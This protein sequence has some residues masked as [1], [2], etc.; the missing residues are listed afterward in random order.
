MQSTAEISHAVLGID[1]AWTAHNP[2]GVALAVRDRTGWRLAAVAARY[3]RFYA[4]A[5]GRPPG[6]RPNGEK[7]DAARLLAAAK[8][9]A[10][11]AVE[12]VAVDMP[13]AMALIE[14][15]RCSDT[16][17]SRAFGAKRCATHSPNKDRPGHIS[18]DVC[19][20]LAKLGYPLAT[21]TLSSPTL[22]E[23][24]P[25]P[26][27]VVWT[28][29]DERL[30]YKAGKAASYWPGA[31]P[32]QRRAKLGEVWRKIVAA[33]EM[34]VAGVGANLPLPAPEVRGWRLEAFEDSLDAVICA[35][36]AADALE[37]RATPYGD[38]K[39]AIWVPRSAPSETARP[40]SV[41]GRPRS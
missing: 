7:P 30:P 35:A 29:A 12:I 28:N 31:D 37:G 27:L 41:S 1:A 26:A 15:R 39:S 14:H 23:V 10:G 3:D 24:Y 32:E 20:G 16:E 33:L 6:D 38:D 2:S 34:R 8:K 18:L 9:L 5:E 13:L 11:R 36:V 22:I 25:H 19:H 40:V 21:T 17:V 4:L